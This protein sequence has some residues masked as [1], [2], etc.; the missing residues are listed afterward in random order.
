M[1]KNKLSSW[2]NTYTG[3]I[4]IQEIGIKNEVHHPTHY[5]SNPSGIECIK[6]IEHYNFCVGNA[7]KYLWRNGLKN[8]PSQSTKNSQIQDLKKAIWYIEREI[9][10][11][12][13]NVYE[14]D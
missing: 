12:E 7:I 13:N 5:N 9:F 2:K 3:P 4:P 10:N 8:S 1:S 11:L 6:V 14:S